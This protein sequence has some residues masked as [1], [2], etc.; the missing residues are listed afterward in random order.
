MSVIPAFRRLQQEGLKSQ[1]SFSYCSEILSRKTKPQV[2]AL[3]V[4]RAVVGQHTEN[5]F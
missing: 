2:S 3:I 1:A 4:K 5:C